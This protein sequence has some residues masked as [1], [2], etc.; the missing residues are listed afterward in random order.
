[1]ILDNDASNRPLSP[2]VQAASTPP[3]TPHPSAQFDPD[4]AI[5]QSNLVRR[6]RG[7][8]HEA[9]TARLCPRIRAKVRGPRT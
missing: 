6:P 3:H 7:G 5:N 4:P 8:S 1:M 2:K 9:L